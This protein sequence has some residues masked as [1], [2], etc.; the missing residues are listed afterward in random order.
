MTPPTHLSPPLSLLPL[1]RSWIPAHSLIS[2]SPFHHAYISSVL[3]IARL[4]TMQRPL[5]SLIHRSPTPPL[6]PVSL[7]PFL[8]LYLLYSSH[9]HHPLTFALALHLFTFTLHTSPS[10][11]SILRVPRA[12]HA[13]PLHLAPR[14]LC[15]PYVSYPY[16]CMRPWPIPRAFSTVIIFF[17]HTF[18]SQHT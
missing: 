15:H 1:P 12:P 6:A 4:S 10:V 14:L 7:P 11:Y 3:P 8:Y 5:T 18:L 17:L 2:L 16:T 9:S 13:F